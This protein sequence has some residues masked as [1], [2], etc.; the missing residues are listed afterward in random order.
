MESSIIFLPCL[1]LEETLK[2]YTEVVGMTLNHRDPAGAVWL[3][4][5]YGLLGFCSYPDGRPMASGV[6]ISFNLKD[7]DA[8]DEK[9]RELSAIGTIEGMTEPQKHPRFGVYSFFFKDPNGYLLE[10]QKLV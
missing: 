5:S 9:Y 10:F 8:V 2:F 1:N 7:T 3:D 6:C 4:S